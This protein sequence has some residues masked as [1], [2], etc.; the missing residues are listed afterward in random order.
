MNTKLTI[1]LSFAL[2]LPVHSQ[3]GV[4]PGL[5][6]SGPGGRGSSHWAEPKNKSQE[7]NHIADPN[8]KPFKDSAEKKFPCRSEEKN[9]SECTDLKSE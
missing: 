3:R 7:K 6:L 9:Q 5:N 2:I 4:H 8:K 1:I